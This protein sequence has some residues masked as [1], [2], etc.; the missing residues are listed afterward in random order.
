MKVY[1]NGCSFSH[2]TQPDYPYNYT[3]EYNGFTYVSPSRQRSVWTEQLGKLY[4]VHFNHARSGTGSD[5]LARTTISFIQHLVD[6][7]DDFSD[8]VFV[9]QASQPAR[10]EI[11]FNSGHFGRIHYVDDPTSPVPHMFDYAY[12]I[13]HLLEEDADNH[14]ED[15]N[16]QLRQNQSF[17]TGVKNYTLIV[18]EDEEI[19]LRHIKNLLL[20]VNMLERYNIKYVFTGMDQSCIWHDGLNLETDITKNLIKLIPE[21]NIVLDIVSVIDNKLEGK[22]RVSREDSHPNAYGHTLFSRYI[23]NEL[24]ERKYI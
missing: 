4:D 8:W 20:I 9:L 23:F 12:D 21:D 13:K 22:N 10:K 3:Y 16:D 2:G 15:M 18:E 5:R 1:T 14:I 19:K 7:Q 17:M 11:L 24:K 6:T